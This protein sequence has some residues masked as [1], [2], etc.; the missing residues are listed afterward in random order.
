MYER[1]QTHF[2]PSTNCEFQPGKT[3]IIDDDCPS[4]HRYSRWNFRLGA[5]LDTLGTF[6]GSVARLSARKLRRISKELIAT[7]QKVGSSKLSGRAIFPLYAQSLS[8]FSDGCNSGGISSLCPK[9][10]QPRHCRN[11]LLE[12]TRL[13]KKHRS[14]VKKNFSF[15]P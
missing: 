14:P 11:H 13:A 5:G 9:P 1:T 12:T 4:A 3:P 2:R 10:R 7:S 6:E 15:P 8:S